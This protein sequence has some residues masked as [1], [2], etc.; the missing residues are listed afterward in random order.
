MNIN[1]AIQSRRAHR[2]THPIEAG[3]EIQDQ[4][5]SVLADAY[6][7]RIA[8]PDRDE[9][10]TEEWLQ[11][12]GFEWQE[13]QE[14]LAGFELTGSD[15]NCLISVKPAD[16]VGHLWSV[17]VMGS[18]WPVDIHVRGQIYDLCHALESPIKTQVN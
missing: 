18:H 15:L 5:A 16:K 3:W 8:Q 4:A 10:V 2:L 14:D 9:K 7:A 6:L 13:D 12:C 1:E 11:S 17:Y